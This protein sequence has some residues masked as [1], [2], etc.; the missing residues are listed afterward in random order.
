MT[1]VILIKKKKEAMSKIKFNQK[2]LLNLFN[3]FF[4]VLFFRLHKLFGGKSRVCSVA[5]SEV[6]T[7]FFQKLIIKYLVFILYNVLFDA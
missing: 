1:E 4:K 6:T 5:A 2:Y 3:F 7:I